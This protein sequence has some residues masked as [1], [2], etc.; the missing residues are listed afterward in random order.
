[1]LN[2]SCCCSLF[3]AIACC[4]SPPILLSFSLSSPSRPLSAPEVAPLMGWSR[5]FRQGWLELFFCCFPGLS[6]K[7][8][9]CVVFERNGWIALSGSTVTPGSFAG[10]IAWT[11]GGQEFAPESWL[12][13]A[14]NFEVCQAL[15]KSRPVTSG[16]R[17]WRGCSLVEIW[18]CP[19]TFE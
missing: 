19:G 17:L 16:S 7:Y 12:A 10:L 11:L 8:Q 14:H 9:D 4:W 13:V 3:P 2:C 15:I 1:M 6:E 18:V 5:P